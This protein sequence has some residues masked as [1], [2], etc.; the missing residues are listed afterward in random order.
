MYIWVFTILALAAH[1]HNPG[2]VHTSL[3]E[4]ELKK[5]PHL[6]ASFLM[7]RTDTVFL[8]NERGVIQAFPVADFS[9]KDKAFI[10]KKTA[11]IE[12]LNDSKRIVQPASGRDSQFDTRLNAWIFG[13]LLLVY[14][15][16][17][18]FLFVKKRKKPAFALAIGGVTF[19]LA[20]K[21]RMVE[22]PVKTDP[23]FI[24]SAFRPFK[25][26]VATRW[27]ANWFYVESN[28]LPTTHSML[29]GITKWQQQVA[30]PQC[31][32]GTNAWQ[33]PL[34]PVLASSPIP[35]NQQ[36]FLRGAIAIAANGIPIFNPYTNTG[37]DAL[38][39]GQLDKWGGHCGR[40]DDYHYHIA[41]M[42]LDTQT[43]DILPIA[44]ALD[45]F[46]VYAGLEPNGSPMLPLDANHGH[47]D[48]VG[49]YH[50]HGSATA[51][52]MI[53]NMV[54]QVTEDATLQI[55]PQSSAKP[56]RPSLTPLTG[57]TI[58]DFTSNTA[59]NGYTLTYTR[60]GQ[61]FQVAYSWTPTGVYSYNFISPTGT[62]TETYNGQLPCVISTS[63]GEI[64]DPTTSIVVFPNPTSGTIN[65][66]LNDLKMSDLPRVQIFDSKGS[67]VFQKEKVSNELEISGLKRGVYF[68]KIQ[69]EKR[70]ISHKVIV[71]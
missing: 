29:S 66:K 40:A 33:I 16:L 50:Y 4:W 22:T 21:T 45:G 46:P 19:L 57:A 24:D 69:F 12:Y 36:H 5:Q 26:H 39:D 61:V 8:E 58:T 43:I 44:F 37:V 47:F 48:G 7:V 59:K 52:Y 30:I 51:P 10:Q 23:L 63:T 42:F 1:A 3:R 41:P 34:N 27:D 67:L 20:F 62:T 17:T 54:G 15:S 6:H 14:A 60:N 65:L 31:Y 18:S 35:V 71:Q 2:E 11:V 53:G 9:E 32:I 56:V 13:L 49:S 68:L 70:E 64:S 55:I 28:G 25:P 38:L